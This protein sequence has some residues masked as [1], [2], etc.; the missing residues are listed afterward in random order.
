MG[1]FNNYY[2]RG[3]DNRKGGGGVRRQQQQ[4]Q[5]RRV[6]NSSTGSSPDPIDFSVNDIV[7]DRRMGSRTDEYSSSTAAAAGGSV[8]WRRNDI[9][10][11]QRQRNSSG[12]NSVMYNRS[13]Y[14]NDSQHHRGGQYSGAQYNSSGQNNNCGQLSSGQYNNSQYSYG[15]YSK[16]DQYSSSQYNNGIQYNYDVQQR[17]RQCS[18][19]QQYN[20]GQYTSGYQNNDSQYNNRRPHNSGQ[21]NSH[22]YNSGGSPSYYP[23]QQSE[24]S[25][26][27]NSVRFDIPPPPPSRYV[28]EPTSNCYSMAMTAGNYGGPTSGSPGMPNAE[29]HSSGYYMQ[30]SVSPD[31][32]GMAATDYGSYD[33]G[34]GRESPF[35]PIIIADILKV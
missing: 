31:V 5:Q 2:G 9:D 12:N 16:Y 27:S 8:N 13:Q 20:R 17:G 7:F 35:A 6:D 1:L 33:S 32:Y 10:F 28:T 11:G 26:F 19:E 18:G 22:Q 29:S 14:N 30:S 21:Y 23:Q 25:S 15:Q 3:C 4:Q 34:Y 24:V